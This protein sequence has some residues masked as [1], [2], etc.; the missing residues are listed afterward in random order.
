MTGGYLEIRGHGEAGRVFAVAGAGLAVQPPRARQVT[1]RD[2]GD[3][4]VDEHVENIMIRC[5]S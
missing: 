5:V 3:I 2:R 1:C 4:I